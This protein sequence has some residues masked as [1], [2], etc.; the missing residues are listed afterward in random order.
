MI[1]ITRIRNYKVKGTNRYE[2]VDGERKSWELRTCVRKF[3]E[4]PE[5][6]KTN[7][8]LFIKLR[9]KIEH[10]H[11]EKSDLDMLIFGECQALLYNF[12][13][14]LI[15]L[16]GDEYAISENLSYSLQFSTLRTKEQDKANKRIISGDMVNIKKFVETFRSLLPQDV[17]DSSE[18]SIKLIQI[19]KIAN[20][21]RNDLAIE[22]VNWSSLSED[23]QK[24]FKKLGALVK[25]KI[26]KEE[27]VNL[28]GLKPSKVLELVEKKSGIKL[29]HH[30]HNCML[31]IFSIRP[32][33][34][35]KKSP[36]ETNTKYCHYDEVHGDYI[37]HDS[38]IDCLCSILEA[39]K[40]KQY[41]WKQAFKSDRRYELDG[42][43]T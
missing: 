34:S 16:F 14:L 3:G 18:Y 13:S 19:P 26:V 2:K 39:D 32:S 11:I 8:D 38:W 37:Y 4:M 36:S 40:M 22:F 9:N 33:K 43:T 1:G 10:R 23:D 27:V 35:S 41:M 6:V 31:T 20:A 21:S 5:S 12:E 30:D 25:S 42:Y 15:E 24:S 17:F 29:S 28:G 7:L